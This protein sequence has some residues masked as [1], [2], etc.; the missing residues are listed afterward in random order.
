MEIMV[1]NLPKSG[2]HLMLSITLA[3]GVAWKGK[4]ITYFDW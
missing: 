3:L 4:P 1:Q 2:W